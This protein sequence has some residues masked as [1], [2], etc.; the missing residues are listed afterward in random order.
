MREFLWFRYP[1]KHHHLD[2]HLTKHR[3]N[4]YLTKHHHPNSYLNK[5]HHPNRSYE[6]LPP[7]PNTKT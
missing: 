7:A 2:S 4:S 5:H 3:P 6:A 1:A